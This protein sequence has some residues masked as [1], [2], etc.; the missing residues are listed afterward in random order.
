S[1]FGETYQSKYS[2]LVV[3]NIYSHKP[4]LSLVRK[5][6]FWLYSMIKLAH[7]VRTLPKGH[8]ITTTPGASLMLC[9]LKR[10][11]FVWENVAFFSAHKNIDFIRF[12]FLLMLAKGI[13]VPTVDELNRLLDQ[14]SFCQH[15]IYFI[16]NWLSGQLSQPKSVHDF[17]IK[18]MAAGALEWR[19]G[20]DILIDSLSLIEIKYRSNFIVDIYGS[21]SMAES[22]V[23][24][25]KKLGLE[26]IVFFKGHVSNIDSYYQNYD[27][28][29]LSSR[30]EGVPLVML[31]A[32]HNGLPVVA[33]DCPTGPS[34]YV[35][36]GYNG[37]LVKDINSN[38]LALAITDFLRI[39]SLNYDSLSE[40]AHVSVS[41]LQCHRVIKRWYAFFS[42]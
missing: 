17:P 21:G 6:V 13:I 10:S 8:Y 31:Q 41:E 18:F 14:F 7:L 22:L 28:F 36:S 23:A 39:Y 19:K 12:P 9:I 11:P 30:Y 34:S 38:A 26:N 37:I 16:P 35:S 40:N 29:L 25:V 24:K 4:G 1:L 15:K 3:Q 27:C 5:S 33:F 2:N 32:L 42:D 20:F